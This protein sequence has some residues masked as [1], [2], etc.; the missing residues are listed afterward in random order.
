VIMTAPDRHPPSHAADDT[1]ALRPLPAYLEVPEPERFVRPRKRKP[2]LLKINVTSLI[3][4]TF[5][6]L[7]Y[8]MIATSFTSSEEAYRTDI[9][10]REGVGTA[11]PFEIQDDP[12]RISV[13]STGLAPDMY[14]LQIDGP[15]Q[16]PSTFDDLYTFLSSRLVR[17]DTTGGLFEPNHPI[18]I[19]PTRTTRW[20][21][22]MQAFNAA[23]RARYTNVTFAKP[24]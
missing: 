9:P 20:E 3:D 11:D 21:H 18:V 12:L 23:A 19:Q 2:M 13:N 4:V 10:S 7:V 6:L 8:F 15:Y 22:A 1:S 5:L 14:R 17:A 24:G 16:Q